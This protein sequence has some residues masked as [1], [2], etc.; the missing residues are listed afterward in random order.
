MEDQFYNQTYFTIIKFVINIISIEII[1]IIKIMK[2]G[3]LAIENIA[4][5]IDFIGLPFSI[6][7]IPINHVGSLE[8]SNNSGCNEPFMEELANRLLASRPFIRRHTL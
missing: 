7:L 5:I 3:W 4:R 2:V 1:T 8:F 6:M